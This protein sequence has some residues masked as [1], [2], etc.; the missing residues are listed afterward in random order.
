MEFL[1]SFV[2]YFLVVTSTYLLL[3]TLVQAARGV[4]PSLIVTL[5]ATTLLSV[6]LY[7][8]LN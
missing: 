6:G 8:L 1:S 5:I 7:A 3:Y 2:P 4:L